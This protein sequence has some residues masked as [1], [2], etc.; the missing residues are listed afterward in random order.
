M[1]QE[2]LAFALNRQASQVNEPETTARNLRIIRE[3]RERRKEP[4]L[5][6]A[7]QVEERLDSAA[8]RMVSKHSGSA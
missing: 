4:S 1:I 6:W 5:A 3:A 8:A 2:Q 7:R